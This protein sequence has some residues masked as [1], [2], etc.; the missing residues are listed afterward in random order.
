MFALV[1]VR[2]IL[3]PL[4]IILSV[5]ASGAGTGNNETIT[6]DIL[7]FK[8][9][10]LN[11]IINQGKNSNDNRETYERLTELANDFNMLVSAFGSVVGRILYWLP[12]SW[13]ATVYIKEL[14]KAIE[15]KLPFLEW[16]LVDQNMHTVGSVGLRSIEKEKYDL[17]DE[18]NSLKLYNIGVILH[19][20][21]Q[22]RGIITQL[23][24]KLFDQLCDLNLDIDGLFIATR[25][26]NVGVN[27]IAK[28]LNFT[29]VK[30]MDV[31]FDG[32]LP[33][34]SSNYLSSNIYVKKLYNKDIIH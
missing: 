3:S 19:S 9:V 25:P 2:L 14:E 22:R 7:H 1:A 15:K 10:E 13:K 12:T 11:N 17:D 30:E 23:T 33:C 4:Q 29:F 24:N 31:E 20:N 26:D 8:Q 27:T 34:C 21:F 5:P 6:E 32:L 18:L 28:K 16:I